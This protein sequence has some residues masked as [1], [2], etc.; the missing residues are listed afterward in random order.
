MNALLIKGVHK[1]LYISVCVLGSFLEII[2]EDSFCTDSV[3]CVLYIF[4]FMIRT[5]CDIGRYADMMNWRVLARI[6]NA[7]GNY[8]RII[9]F[10]MIIYRRDKAFAGGPLTHQNPSASVPDGSRDNLGTPVRCSV[11]Q[12]YDRKAQIFFGFWICEKSGIGMR[13]TSFCIGDDSRVNKQIGDI[14]AGVKKSAGII[15]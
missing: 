14:D 1:H 5:H 13:Q 10:Q 4:W 11:D 8:K 9:H 7:A 15:P 6:V 2:F 3:P 12:D